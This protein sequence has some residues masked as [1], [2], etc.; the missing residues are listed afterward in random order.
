MDT[1]SHFN[2]LKALPVS[3]ALLLIRGYQLLV[4]PMMGTR[5]RY[6]PCC[7]NYAME[8]LQLHGCAKGTWLAAKRILRCHPYS[9][10]GLD[11]V[12]AL[13]TSLQK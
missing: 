2:R 6:Y 12:P 4:S 11:P 9:S 10:G 1:Q 13:K 8:A 3:S 7:S 5:C